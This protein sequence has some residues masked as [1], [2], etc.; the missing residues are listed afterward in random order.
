MLVFLDENGV[1][2][3]CEE[4]ELFR[5]VLRLAQHALVIAE[6]RDLPDAEVLAVAQW[7]RKNSR[8][9]ERGDRA[10]AFRK[11]RQ[12]LTSYDCTFSFPN[13]GNR[14]NI[15]R[16][17]RVPSLFGI[18]SRSR[19]LR[20]Q[21]HYGDEGRDVDKTTINKLRKELHLDDQ[22]GIDSAAFYDRAAT[23]PSD[24]VTVYRKTLRRL[25]RL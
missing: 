22:H 12:I 7:L 10:L 21:V 9:V 23:S 3:T 14:I 24:F 1:V 4:E 25:A 5:L 18:S 13:T 6:R 19:T 15:E 11:L 20:T 16:T 8:L 17:V 2:L